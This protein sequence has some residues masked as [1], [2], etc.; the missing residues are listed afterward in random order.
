[1][2]IEFTGPRIE[3]IAGWAR[4]VRVGDQEYGCSVR[5]GKSVRIM[6]KPR[7]QNRGWHWH[8]SVYRIGANAG[9]VW[10]GRVPGSIGCRGLL[11]EAG[12]IDDGIHE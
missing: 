3:T 12:I 4:T 9:H 2:K 5:R 10:T 11:H 6:Y 1:M 8:G 7:G